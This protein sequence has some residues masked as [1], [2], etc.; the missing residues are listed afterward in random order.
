MKKVVRLTES[1]LVRIVKKVINEDD[2][3]FSF[4]DKIKSKLGTFRK[5]LTKPDNIWVS[6]FKKENP[7]ISIVLFNI[8]LLNNK[9]K[10]WNETHYDVNPYD[11]SKVDRLVLKNGEDLPPV[12]IEK[13]KNNEFHI[14]DGWHRLSAAQKRGDT[15]IKALVK[16]YYT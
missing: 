6:D 1:D 2:G 5:N 3:A 14:M 8:D 12:I 9:L 10:K 11:K 13:D 7:K 16:N 15:K 4:G